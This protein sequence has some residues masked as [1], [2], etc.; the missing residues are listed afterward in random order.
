[1]HF[2]CWSRQ[3]PSLQG[4]LRPVQRPGLPVLPRGTG[5][6]VVQHF[7]GQLRW[8]VERTDRP[9]PLGRAHRQAERTLP[10]IS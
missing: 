3:Q 4:L 1:M 7:T 10:I 2:R 9:K 5:P 8:L 6:G